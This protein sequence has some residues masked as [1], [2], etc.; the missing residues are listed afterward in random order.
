MTFWLHNIQAD[1]EGIL[2]INDDSLGTKLWKHSDK[3]E[4]AMYFKGSMYL[5]NL[6]WVLAYTIRVDNFH[7]SYS[8]HI[9]LQPRENQSNVCIKNSI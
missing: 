6:I 5:G 8:T 1:G 3:K 4:V 7:I 2:S 9:V